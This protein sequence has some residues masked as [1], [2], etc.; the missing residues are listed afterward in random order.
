MDESFSVSWVDRWRSPDEWQGQLQR[1]QRWLDMGKGLVM[2]GQGPQD[3][4]SRMDFTLASFLLVANENAFFRYTRFDSYYN[5][6]WLYPEYDTARSLG[7][8]LGVCREVSGGVWHR[9]FEHGY[10]EANPTEHW[11]R[12]V[13]QK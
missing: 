12:V 2:V 8:P 7:L 3:D 11:G 13:V 4:T 5:S 1:A 6:L 10:V 9:D